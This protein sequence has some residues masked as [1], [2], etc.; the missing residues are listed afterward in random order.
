MFLGACLEPGK[1]SL[2]EKNYPRFFSSPCTPPIIDCFDIS[3]VETV[4]EL[5][6][7]DLSDMIFNDKLY[8]SLYDKLQLARDIAKG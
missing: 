3:C 6:K 2:G 7:G 8:L 5:C 4:M 1:W